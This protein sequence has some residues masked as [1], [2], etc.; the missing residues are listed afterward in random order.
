M[1]G[2]RLFGTMI[3]IFCA[4]SVPKKFNFF[5]ALGVHM[6]RGY[7]LPPP[8]LSKIPEFQNPLGQVEIGPYLYC[9][10]PPLKQ[11]PVLQCLL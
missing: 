6:G 11:A 8:P 1:P 4:P 2:K 5:R 7:P 9:A 10:I 3:F